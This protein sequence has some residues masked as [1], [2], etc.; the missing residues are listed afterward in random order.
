M[1]KI[2]RTY[3]FYT[4]N[5]IDSS[6]DCLKGEYMVPGCK[7]LSHRALIVPYACNKT[8]LIHNLNR[9]TDVKATKIAIEKLGASFT[10]PTPTSKSLLLTPL[11]FLPSSEPLHN[12]EIDCGNSGTSVRLLMGL[13]ASLPMVTVHLRGDESLS[14]RPMARVAT[15]LR[16]MGANIQLSDPKEV[17]RESQRS[18]QPTLPAFIKGTFLKG[19]RSLEMTSPSAQVKSAILLA[20]LRAEGPTRIIDR[21]PSRDHT[22]NLL[23]FLGHPVYKEGNILTI[24]PLPNAPFPALLH[25]A[26]REMSELTIPGDPSAA[27]FWCV[28]AS[29]CEGSHIMIQNINANPY[30]IEFLKVLQAMGARIQLTCKGKAMN[31]PLIDIEVKN[32]RLT[33]IITSA[34]QASS[35]IDE[36]PILSV[37]AAFAQGCSEFHGISELKHKESDRLLKITQLLQAFGVNVKIREDTLMIEGLTFHDTKEP[38]YF[39][40]A[41]DHRIAM[42]AIILAKAL[43]RPLYY[44]DGESIDTSFPSFR[45][46]LG[47]RLSEDKFA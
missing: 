3:D 14:T 32:A 8:V 44:S 29:I 42:S 38:V 5:N 46:Q 4:P 28:A 18:S 40:T 27:A 47:G 41:F 2:Q 35:L 24:Y 36:Y 23:A 21:F 20:A 37:A 45:Q 34:S 9:G 43:K 33:S 10:S 13:C 7:S 6:Y 22:E 19:H 26:H 15:P 1:T 16:L 25:T 31:E 30:R 17:V 12:V 39:D 11:P